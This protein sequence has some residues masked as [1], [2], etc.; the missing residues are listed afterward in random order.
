MVDSLCIDAIAAIRALRARPGIPVAVVLTIALAVGINLAMLG[1]IDRALLSPPAH[2][3]EPERVF[4]IAFVHSSRGAESAV[5]STTSL[6]MFEAIRNHV[7]AVRTR[8][9][10]TWPRAVRTSTASGSP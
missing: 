3:A 4:T 7:P 1:L 5:T 8:P 9:R 10:G 6:P 2:V